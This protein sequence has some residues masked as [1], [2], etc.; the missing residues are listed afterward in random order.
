MSKN[1]SRVILEFPDQETADDFCAWW[2]DGGGEAY[3][4]D[5]G[6][7]DMDVASQIIRCDYRKCFPG[8]GY[9]P[10]KHGDK[11]IVFQTRE[12]RSNV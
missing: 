1:P 9:D 2:S 7:I 8:W 6:Q 11:T 5:Y 12:M 3:Y 10:D 4:F